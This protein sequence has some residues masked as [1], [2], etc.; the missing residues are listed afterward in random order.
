M[1]DADVFVRPVKEYPN[2]PND[3]T[4][5]PLS[6]RFFHAHPGIKPW[7]VICNRFAVESDWSFQSPVLATGLPQ[8]AI[9]YLLFAILKP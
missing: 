6:G 3:P 4:R 5:P 7:A 8:F 9:C 1:R 2:L